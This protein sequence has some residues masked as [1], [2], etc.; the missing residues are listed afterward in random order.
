[1]KRSVHLKTRQEIEIM[2]EG[3]LILQRVMKDLLPVVKSGKTTNEID[4]VAQ[5]LLLKYGADISFQT[6]SGYSWATCLPVNAQAVHTPPSN[7]I[8]QNGD[9]LTI[10]IG[11]LFKGYHTDYATTICVGGTCDKEKKIF[12]QAGE[13]I[14]NAALKK[15]KAGV[16][17]GEIGQFIHQEISQKGYFILKQLTGHGI[18]KELH[19]DPYVLNYLSGSKEKTFKVQDGLTIAV[20]IIY[21]MGTEQIEYESPGAW[22]IVTADRSLSACFEHTIA[23]IDGSASILV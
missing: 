1:M 10:D 7:Y 22:S 19:E 8:L 6:V 5:K 16:Y 23:I 21:S 9:L 13:E 14:L 12:L 3:G 15:I 4:Q 20:E 18:G 11:A 17:L 2:R